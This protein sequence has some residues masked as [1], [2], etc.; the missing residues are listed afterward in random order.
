[1]MNPILESFLEKHRVLH[2]SSFS[3]E[4]AHSTPL[5]YAFEAEPFSLICISQESSR[6]MNEIKKE[7][8]VSASIASAIH[9]GEDL[10]GIQL[11]GKAQLLKNEDPKVK[12]YYQRF[13]ESK[14]HSLVKKETL[15]F[16]ILVEKIR[17]IQ[18]FLGL[19][20]RK[21]WSIEGEQWTRIK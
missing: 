12:L 9:Q 17:W 5:C 2:L 15:F 1:M 19:P 21:E 6:H 14:L 4:G 10:E 7:D 16:Q 11:W 18:T 3:S 13:P 8:K 20:Q